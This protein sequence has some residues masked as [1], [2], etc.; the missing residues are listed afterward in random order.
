LIE[1]NTFRRFEGTGLLKIFAVDGL[2]WRNN[3]IEET[4]AYPARKPAG[5]LFDVSYSDNVQ[6][7]E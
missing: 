3:R 6:I 7:E 2:I 4:E 1:G 5:G